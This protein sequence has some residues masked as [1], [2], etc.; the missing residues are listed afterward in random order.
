VWS[1][2]PVAAISP[3]EAFFALRERVPAARAVGRMAA[4]TAAPY[5]PGIPALAPGELITEEILVALQREAAA[6]TRV[7]YCSDPTLETLLVVADRPV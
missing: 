6:G 5:P 3:R 7:A 1:L 2:Q 4:E